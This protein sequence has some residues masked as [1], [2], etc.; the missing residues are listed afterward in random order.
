MKCTNTKLGGVTNT[1]KDRNIMQRGQGEMWQEITKQATTHKKHANTLNVEQY[2]SVRENPQK[3]QHWKRFQEQHIRYAVQ[4]D[5][6]AIKA[7]I[8]SATYEKA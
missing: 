1:T 2:E 5:M 3:Q 7:N 4:R 8:F 6:L